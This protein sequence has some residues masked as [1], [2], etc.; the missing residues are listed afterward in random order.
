M[1]PS[2]DPDAKLTQEK[3]ALLGELEGILQVKSTETRL[4]GRARLVTT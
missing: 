1:L 2:D 3:I 4:Q